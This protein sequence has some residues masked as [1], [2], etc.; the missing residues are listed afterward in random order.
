MTAIEIF[1]GPR[2]SCIPSI[3]P[4]TAIRATER[5]L[6]LTMPACSLV[7]VQIGE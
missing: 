1:M 7:S 3:Q 5:G 6:V 2:E 4:F